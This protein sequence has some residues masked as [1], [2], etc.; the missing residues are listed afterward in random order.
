MQEMEMEMEMVL[1]PLEHLEGSRLKLDRGVWLR[2]GL[3]QHW[4][5]MGEN[6]DEN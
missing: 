6:V 5:L 2:M 1:D 4:E 3:M